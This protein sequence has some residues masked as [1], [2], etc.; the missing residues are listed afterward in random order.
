MIPRTDYARLFSELGGQF[1]NG[2]P[3]IHSPLS[4]TTLGTPYL[5]SPGVVLIARPKTSLAGLEEFLLGFPDPLQF[6]DYLADS[7][8]LP[9]ATTLCKAAAQTCYMSFGPKRTLNRDVSKYFANI[10]ASGHGSVL[11]HPTFTFLL[12][13]VSR[14]FTHELVRHRAGTAYSQVSQRFVDAHVLRFVERPE[15]QRSVE[16]HGRFEEGIDRVAQEYR[17]RTELLKATIKRSP[18][19]DAESGVTARRKQIQQAAR[20]CL[21]NEV[22]A[23]IVFSANV[24]ALRHMTEMRAAREAEGEMRGVVFRIFLCLAQTEPVLFEDYELCVL[25]D[26]SHT[27]ATPYTKV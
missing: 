23:P 2:F 15:Y 26:G 24:R 4:R 14:S 6:V 13:G 8:S 17:T 22:E 1:V 27:V 18:G 20:G 10:K 12:Y 19:N 3:S 25:A 21:S 11:E 16:L 7:D 5:R 9:N